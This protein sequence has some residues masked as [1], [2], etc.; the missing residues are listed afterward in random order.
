MDRM[1]QQSF[2]ERE[3]CHLDLF[4]ATR[5]LDCSAH[6]ALFQ[7]SVPLVTACCIRRNCSGGAGSLWSYQNSSKS[8][9]S[10]FDPDSFLFGDK[11]ISPLHLN[12]LFLLSRH[13]FFSFLLG[14][15]LP[16]SIHSCEHYPMWI[17]F[18]DLP[19][20]SQ[21]CCSNKN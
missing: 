15:S 7:H 16:G 10:C 11:L 12:F 3:A 13:C 6:L 17:L 5:C 20:L 14:Y 4:P 18:Q 2:P 8:H 19:P 9:S 1:L 21:S